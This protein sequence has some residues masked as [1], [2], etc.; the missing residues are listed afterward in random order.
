MTLF[1]NRDF[2]A[3][4][5]VVI[6]EIMARV[7]ELSGD[8]V[9]VETAQAEGGGTRVIHEYQRVEGVSDLPMVNTGS[10]VFLPGELIGLSGGA[11]ALALAP[12][13]RALGVCTAL[14]TPGEAVL[15]SRGGLQSVLVE[16]GVLPVADDPAFLSFTQAGR[17]TPTRPSG[18]AQL[19]G[20]F[21]GATD[22]TGKANVYLVANLNILRGVS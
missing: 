17:V 11:L 22:S 21:A 7:N 10:T 12:G 19:V 8:V 13:I 16:D 9:R 15:H 4:V 18:G 1:R 20:Q 3:E 2:G 5:N 14:A 6:D